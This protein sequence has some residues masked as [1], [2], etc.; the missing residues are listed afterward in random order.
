MEVGIMLKSATAPIKSII[1]GQIIPVGEFE[2]GWQELVLKRQ[3]MIDEKL[4]A[5]GLSSEC[6]VEILEKLGK[7]ELAEDIK[8]A[9]FHLQTSA[10]YMQYNKGFLDGIKFTMMA[11]QL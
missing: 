1:T 11:N 4:D 10:T 8:E 9:I 6:L 7:K 5:V 3:V 2:E